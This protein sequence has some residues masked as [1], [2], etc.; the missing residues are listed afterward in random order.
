M[1]NAVLVSLRILVST[2]A[3]SKAL[4]E[5]S[6]ASIRTAFREAGASF[7]ERGDDEGGRDLV[8]LSLWTFG[9]LR[10]V[11]AAG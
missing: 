11:R 10:R 7:Y 2:L 4:D 3:E 8:D 6:L 5:A 1:D 9:A